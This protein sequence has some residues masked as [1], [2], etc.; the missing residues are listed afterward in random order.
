MSPPST[1]STGFDPLTTVVGVHGTL[2]ACPTLPA[3]D[4]HLAELCE[5][6]RRATPRFPQLVREFRDEIDL[7]L[8]RRQWL[9]L[10]LGV[11]PEAA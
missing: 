9:E 3:L 10:D 7:L 4:R 6:I 1:T 5:R 2:Y 11:V 8:D